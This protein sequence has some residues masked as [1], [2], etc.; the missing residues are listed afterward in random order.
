M[1]GERFLRTVR[2]GWDRRGDRGGAEEVRVLSREASVRRGVWPQAH[3][4]PAGGRD[5]VH[6][7]L[8][9]P[10]AA[11]TREVQEET[12]LVGGLVGGWASFLFVVP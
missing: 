4:L 11:G 9:R 5:G 10:G 3:S 7:W 1:L 6:L 8:Q 2:L 12:R